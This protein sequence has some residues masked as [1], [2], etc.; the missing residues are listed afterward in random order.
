MDAF[1]ATI[2]LSGRFAAEK[3]DAFDPATQLDRQQRDRFGNAMSLEEP[4]AV[5]ELRVNSDLDGGAIVVAGLEERSRLGQDQR[6]GVL[7]VELAWTDTDVG[8][9]LGR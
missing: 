1:P 7:V 4:V 2:G 5:D 6:V 9:A 8:N 3:A